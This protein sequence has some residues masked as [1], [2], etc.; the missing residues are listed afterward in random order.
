MSGENLAEL[1]NQETSSPDGE[2]KDS[3]AQL[4]LLKAEEK[5]LGD[6]LDSTKAAREAE[7]ARLYALM[8]SAGFQRVTTDAG[9]FY[10][11]DDLYASEEDKVKVRAWLREHDH[12]DLIT[13][14]VNVRTLSAFVKELREHGK[15]VP[16]GVAITLKKRIGVRAK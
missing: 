14:I 5:K 13:E 4:V 15:E 2:L 1:F 11:K 10:R 16:P 6:E 8:E 3:L 9:T 12:G 7:E